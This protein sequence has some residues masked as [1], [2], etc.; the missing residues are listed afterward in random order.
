MKIIIKTMTRMM[1]LENDNNIYFLCKFIVN[2]FFIE[3]IKNDILIF[4]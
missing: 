4:L 3:N 1:N 2:Y